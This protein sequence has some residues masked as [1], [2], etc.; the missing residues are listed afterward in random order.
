MLAGRQ[1]QPKVISQFIVFPGIG[2][3]I[4]FQ[5]KY[6]LTENVYLKIALGKCDALVGL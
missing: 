3:I 2:F 6:F 1:Q 4:Q 5:T